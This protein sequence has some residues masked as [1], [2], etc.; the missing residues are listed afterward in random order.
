MNKNQKGK[1]SRPPLKANVQAKTVSPVY[2]SVEKMLEG[3]SL[4]VFLGLAGF[5]VLVVFRHFITFRDL[6]LY[7]DIGCDTV[8]YWWPHY[9]QFSHYIHTEGI[10][11]WAFNYGMG[12]NVYAFGIEDPFTFFLCL[13]PQDSIPYGIIF[14]EII[15]I[16]GGGLFF[17]L[18][19]RTL[20]I[21]RLASVAGGLLYSFSGYMIL[22]SGWY[23]VSAEA[24]YIA[25]VLYCA[26]RFLRHGVWY[27][28]PI[29]FCLIGILQPFYIYLDALLL[30][31][32]CIA[33]GLLNN[34]K[35]KEIVISLFKIGGLALFGVLLG[36]VFIFANVYQLIDNPRVSGQASLVK[37]LSSTPMFQLTPSHL[38][39]MAVYRMFSNDLMG[40]GSVFQ[41]GGSNYLEAP[42]LYI[43]LLSLLL[44]PQAFLFLLKEKGISI[45]FL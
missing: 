27:L 31:V 3:K 2:P 5:L 44:A 9:V 37:M 14:M 8:T 4:Y 12:Q 38:S 35:W 43:G 1:T 18:F 7:K 36:S 10:P 16:I 41:Q 26:E 17:Y 21:S 19:L 15:K 20:T 32:Y 42:I 6:Y 28:L 29:P 34:Q 11:K 23:L 40:A 25:M 45:L 24:F 33:R 22:G 30:T 39:Q 13:L